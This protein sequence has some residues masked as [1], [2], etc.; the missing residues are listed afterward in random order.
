MNAKDMNL[1]Q[2]IT[3]V[4]NN[5]PQKI[6]EVLSNW[7]GVLLSSLVFCGTFLGARLP[8][9]AYIAVAVTIDGIWGVVTAKKAG[10]FI[11][12][13]LLAKSAVKIAAY[14]SIYAL[15]ALI[16]KGF[17]GSEFTFSSSVIAAILI[18][19]EL[20]STLGHI[21][22]SNPDWLVT[23]ILRMY[24]KGEMAKKLGINEEEL[25][26]VLKSSD[27]SK[28]KNNKKDGTGTKNSI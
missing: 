15:V 18:A 20:W 23:K 28:K 13:R 3:D 24:L 27:K 14:S 25:D 21:S 8:L 9:L 22:I 4:V 26:K 11:F 12:S 7:A 10:R 1:S 5:I 16:E 19:S 2:I 6:Y 17:V